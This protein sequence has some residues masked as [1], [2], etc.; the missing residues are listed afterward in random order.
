MD[1]RLQ[2]KFWIRNFY[3]KYLVLNNR[4]IGEKIILSLYWTRGYDDY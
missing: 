3:Q 4:L 1:N 2:S